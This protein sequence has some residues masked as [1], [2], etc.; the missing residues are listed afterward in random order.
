ME[1]KRIIHRS[2]KRISVAFPYNQ[3]IIIIIKKI[4]GAK[5]SSTL[6]A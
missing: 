2:E 5:W 1:I 3:E 6:K 4:E